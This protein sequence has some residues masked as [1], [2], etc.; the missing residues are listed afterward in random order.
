MDRFATRAGGLN[1]RQTLM[2]AGGQDLLKGTPV[3][4]VCETGPLQC[5]LIRIDNVIGKP[6]IQQALS[7]MPH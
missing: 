2:K 5:W 6:E 4:D 3:Y 7:R 1:W